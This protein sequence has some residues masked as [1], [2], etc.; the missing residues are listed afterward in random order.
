MFAGSGTINATTIENLTQDQLEEKIKQAALESLE[1]PSPKIV[2]LIQ[3]E[4]LYHIA[5][6]NKDVIL[7][8]ALCEIIDEFK[9]INEQDL[10]AEAIILHKTL[11][12]PT[13][14]K[15]FN[16]LLNLF[17]KKSKK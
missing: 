14:T 2:E 5:K 4:Q 3:L 17:F 9:K 15:E 16:N 7:C 13:K 8:K 12:T 6:K 10:K 1:L 11:K